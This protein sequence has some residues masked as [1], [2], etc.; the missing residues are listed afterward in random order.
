VTVNNASGT[1]SVMDIND[2]RVKSNFALKGAFLGSVA[3][4][5]NTNVCLIVDQVNNRLLFVP[6]PD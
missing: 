2:G 5:P 3:I 1:I 4:V 6:M